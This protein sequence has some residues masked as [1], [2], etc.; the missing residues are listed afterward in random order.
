[1]F[2]AY[3]D[4]CDGDFIGSY[5]NHRCKMIEFN[6]KRPKN[7]QETIIKNSINYI[8]KIFGI[9]SALEIVQYYSDK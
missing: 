2:F 1:M 9:S 4:L 8:N 5:H 3:E 7:S 6:N